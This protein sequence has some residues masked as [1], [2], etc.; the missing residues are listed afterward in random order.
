MVLLA[1]VCVTAAAQV[2]FQ[3]FPKF[4]LI[5]DMSGDGSVVV[6]AYDDG[7]NKPSAFRWT[8]SGG[9]EVIGVDGIGDVRISR[10]GS[11]IVS[12]VRDS[13]GCATAAIWKGGKNWML[14]P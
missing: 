11:T 3:E 10:D 2:T 7:V 9:I 12:T 4:A 5:N 14:L 6:G 8:A 1:G 13:K